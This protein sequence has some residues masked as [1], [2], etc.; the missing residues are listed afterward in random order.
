MHSNTLDLSR[1]G[2]C[3]NDEK[4]VFFKADFFNEKAE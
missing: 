4:Y 1:L 3:S 2:D